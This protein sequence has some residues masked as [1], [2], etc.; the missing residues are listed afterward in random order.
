[1]STSNETQASITGAA[2]A[3][4]RALRRAAEI[5]EA[6]DR[7][8]FG[9]ED[10]LAVLLDDDRSLLGAHA[11][12]QGL[13]EQFEEIRRLARSLV[14]GAVGG[15]STPAGPAG[16][17]FTISGPDAAELEAFVRA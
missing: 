8:W 17:D 12:R 10:V 14:P 9:I 5:A 3:L 6:N 13:T 15:P 16:V 4:I 1:M 7:G 2:P 11:A